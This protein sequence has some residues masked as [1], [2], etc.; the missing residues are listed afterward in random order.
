MM[1]VFVPPVVV[2]TVAVLLDNHNLLVPAIVSGFSCSAGGKRDREAEHRKSNRRDDELAHFRLLLDGF[3]DEV[4]TADQ[5]GDTDQH[6]D[7]KGWH[8]YSPFTRLLT[9]SLS[10][11]LLSGRLQIPA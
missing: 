9:P 2:S 11:W 6:W 10:V 1:A 3:D 8:D 4:A 5:N 7:D